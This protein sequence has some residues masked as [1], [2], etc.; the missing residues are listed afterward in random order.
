MAWMSERSAGSST[1]WMDS[2]REW[3]SMELNPAG[4]P[5][6]VGSVGQRQRDELQ[7]G[8]MTGPALG[9]Q[10]PHASLQAWG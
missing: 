2:P 4:G 3:W 9:P 8:Q 10:Q 6:Q 7:Q 1:G 5:S